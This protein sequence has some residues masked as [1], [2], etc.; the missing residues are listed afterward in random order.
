MVQQH[1]SEGEN[2]PHFQDAKQCSSHFVGEP[3]RHQIQGFLDQFGQQMNRHH[4]EHKRQ[5][6]RR[7][8]DGVDGPMDMLSEGVRHHM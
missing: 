6:Q 1:H 3:Q 4:H 8:M 5:G 2:H 7:H